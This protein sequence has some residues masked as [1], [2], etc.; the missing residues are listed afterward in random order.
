MR[1]WIGGQQALMPE[2][3]AMIACTVNSYTRLIPGFLGADGRDLGLREP[4]LRAAGHHGLGKVAARRV[5]D[6]RGGHQSVHRARRGD[7]IG[8]V[9]RRASHRAGRADRR[10]CLRQ[11]ASR[12]APAA[13]H[14]LG[15]SAASQG[16][17]SRRANCSATPSSSITPRPGS[18][19]SGNFA[20]RSPTGRWI[21]ISKSSNR[22]ITR[23][24]FAGRRSGELS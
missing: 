12:R 2:L 20:R 4:H 13:A 24:G 18:G 1:W 15:R 22:E 16:A 14:A 9:G 3:L 7:R 5:P 23:A 19:R 8:P 6:R 10:Q 17:P 11:D 21:A